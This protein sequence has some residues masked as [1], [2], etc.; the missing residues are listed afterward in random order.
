MIAMITIAGTPVMGFAF[1]A[2]IPYYIIVVL[3]CF[4]V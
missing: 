2:Y 3:F 1:S 4:R